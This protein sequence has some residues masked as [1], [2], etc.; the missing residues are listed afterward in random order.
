VPAG[1]T[2]TPTEQGRLDRAVRNA[3]AASRELS[4]ALYLGPTEGP[5]RSA[6]EALH[7]SLVASESSVLVLCDPDRHALEIVTGSLARRTLTD[8]ECALAAASM[9]SNFAAGDIVGG[10]VLGIQQLGEAARAPRTLHSQH[11]N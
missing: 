11:R 5:T 1:S 4:F 8:T 10:L 2:L 3:E 7:A 6:A 9:E